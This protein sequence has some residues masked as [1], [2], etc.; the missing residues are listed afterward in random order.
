VILEK[1]LLKTFLPLLPF[2]LH[3]VIPSFLENWPSFVLLINMIFSP[4]G[5]LQTPGVIILNLVTI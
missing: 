4:Y 1:G 2:N 3:L 5:L